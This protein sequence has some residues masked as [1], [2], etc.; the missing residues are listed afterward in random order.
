MMNKTIQMKKRSTD[1]YSIVKYF[2]SLL[3]LPQRTMAQLCGFAAGEG[4][5]NTDYNNSLL[6][7]TTAA[8]L[9]YNNFVSTYHT[10]MIRTSSGGFKV[11]GEGIANDGISNVLSP[12]DLNN[13]NYPA[14]GSAKI[15]KVTGA[16]N[17]TTQSTPYTSQSQFIAL[18]ADGLYASGISGQILSTSIKS[19]RPFQKI[20]VNGKTDGLPPR[21]SPADVKMMAASSNILA[22]LTTPVITSNLLIVTCSGDVW[23]LSQKPSTRSNGN[24]GSATVWSRVQTS[25]TGIVAARINA[26][27][28][29]MDNIKWILPSEHIGGTNSPDWKINVLTTVGQVY[30][31]V[32]T[33]VYDTIN[34]CMK[35]YTLKDKD[36]AM[37]WHCLTT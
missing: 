37:A 36:S 6:K 31:W 13:T 33:I 35:I 27:G 12:L 18:T 11:W 26:A 17:G 9:E 1:Y 15:Y 4:C 19:T 7:S 30:S 5:S 2:C 14:L 29:V 8:T 22:N 32:R 21:V 34:K 16:S 20:A 3:M 25:A 10:T 24:T 23:A 28:T